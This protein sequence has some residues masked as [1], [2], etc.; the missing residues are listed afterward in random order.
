MQKKALTASGTLNV[1][2]LPM[3]GENPVNAGG[4][5]S[6]ELEW[7]GPQFALTMGWWLAC[8]VNILNLSWTGNGSSTAVDMVADARIPAGRR[9]M[10]QS[11]TGKKGRW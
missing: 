4:M 8:K 2:G 6:T 5:I 9:L 1:R 3:A 7:N 11:T 10:S